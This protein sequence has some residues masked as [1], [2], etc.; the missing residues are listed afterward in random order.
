ME[1]VIGRMMVK[2]YFFKFYLVEN[3]RN[4]IGYLLKS[5]CGKTII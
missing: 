3:N 1:S 5:Y 4:F 2:E